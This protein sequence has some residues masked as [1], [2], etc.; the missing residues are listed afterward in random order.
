MPEEVL[1]KK[2]W[3]VRVIAIL[4][5][6]SGL[7]LFLLGILPAIR[8]AVQG[9]GTGLG[10][11]LAIPS[12]LFGCAG[13]LFLLVA[14]SVLLTV[15]KIAENIA[16][17]RQPA[18][19]RVAVPAAPSPLPVVITQEPARPAPVVAALPVAAMPVAE[20]VALP[21]AESTITEPA[22]AA[23]VLAGAI[24]ADEQPAAEPPPAAEIVEDALAPAPIEAA[25]LE[26]TEAPAEPGLLVFEAAGV[27]AIVAPEEVA[28]APAAAES[29]VVDRP[30]PP[31]VATVAAAELQPAA[32]LSPQE[33]VS[34]LEA[35]LAALQ[36]QLDQL[37]GVSPSSEELPAVVEDEGPAPGATEELKL[38]GTVD[39][40]RVAAEMAALH[41]EPEV[42][43]S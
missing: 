24:I 5:L 21:A 10:V 28:P 15:G 36:A 8:V 18:P 7:S 17:A 2:R 29:S 40:A 19:E 34:A 32:A 41:L 42:E 27:E 39:A 12:A 35:Q 22:V 31:P 9:A 33:E 23:G 11:W 16:A 14:G 43:A 20:A 13:A 25:E 6:I 30:S 3:G 37:E 4:M 38:P 26:E 1:M